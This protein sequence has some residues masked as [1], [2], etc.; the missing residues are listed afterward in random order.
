[1]KK[2]LIAFTVVAMLSLNMTDA[3]AA[4]TLKEI[5]AYLTDAK[6]Y[7]DGNE[8]AMPEG[9]API[10]YKGSIYVPVR[11]VSDK[12]GI[13]VIWDGK[14]NNVLL[15]SPTGGNGSDGDSV[16][17]ERIDQLTRENK[18][19]KNNSSSPSGSSDWT[20]YQT[21]S[22]TIYMTPKVESHFKYLATDA[23]KMLS[24]H[25]NFFGTGIMKKNVDIWIHD[26]DGIFEL[27]NGAF[28]NPQFMALHL[29]PFG[30]R[31]V[32]NDGRFTFVHEMTHAYQDQ[33]WG[34]GKLGEKLQGRLNWLLEGQADYVAKKVAGFTQYGSFVDPAGAQ[35]DLSF[36]KAE[37][38]KRNSATGYS[39][40]D[41]SKVTRF[42]DLNAYPNEYFASEAT[43]FFFE[44]NYSH[45]QYLKLF[46]EIVKGTDLSTSFKNAFGKSN[47]DLMK[48]FKEYLNIK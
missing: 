25:E 4:S 38:A 19:L 8:Q 22:T 16:L 2:K 5:K 42:E 24:V 17:Q 15:D 37:I 45:D 10:S 29:S 18:E 40:I 21:K 12:L 13:H 26:N 3:F 20:K 30:D 31:D 7:L 41:W 47:E 39:P 48:E 28:Y 34:I 33:R 27:F 32:G 23:E 46:D 9:M 1:M 14:N 35:R 6:I 44:N 43:V 36:Y 11:F